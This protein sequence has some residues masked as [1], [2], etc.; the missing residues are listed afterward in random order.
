[1]PDVSCMNPVNKALWFIETHYA[2]EISLEEIAVIA[3]V[4]RYHLTRA[5]TIATGQSALRYTRGRRLSEAARALA[6]GA[7][8]ILTLALEVG[9]NSHE[10]FTR[11]FR[12]Q[13]GVTPE[14]V[15]GQRHLDNIQ[16]VEALKMDETL[17]TRLEPPRFEE[18]PAMLLAGL[19]ARFD[20]ESSSGI[21]AQW[22]KFVPHIG[23]IPGQIGGAA[24]GV[25][26]NSDEEGTFDYLCA[27]QASDFSQLPP[28]WARLRVAARR[29]AV[30]AH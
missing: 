6:A 18:R 26:Y 2:R 13:F 27:V 22:Q 15:R 8:D 17:L 10:A 1:M 29:Y 7:P 5:F 28:D 30:F 16:L 25:R 21:P 24:Y 20:C 9:Y 3:G 12:D 4:S 23:T 19:S 11:A 14:S